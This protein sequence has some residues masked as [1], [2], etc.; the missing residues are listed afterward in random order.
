M[1]ESSQEQHR[2]GPI[3]Q[4]LLFHSKEL[5]GRQREQQLL[6]Q[7]FRRVGDKAT[8]TSE[9]VFVHGEAGAGKSALVQS[10][11]ALLLADAHHNDDL[12]GRTHLFA[13][14]KYEQQGT[15]DP[16]SAIS[17]V[18]SDLI[19]SVTNDNVHRLASI[20]TAILEAV[21]AEDL[22]MLPSLIPNLNRIVC[23]AQRRSRFTGRSNQEYAFSKLV[24]A[25]C[26]FVRSLIAATKPTVIVLDDMQFAPVL[27]I[28]LIRALASDKTIS[29]MLL[30]LTYRAGEGDTKR[31]S[32]LTQFLDTMLH[33]SPSEDHRFRHPVTEIKVGNLMLNDI[34]QIVR[35]ITKIQDDEITLPLGLVIVQK[36]QGHAFHVVQFLEMLRSR[37]LMWYENGRYIFDIARIRQET[38]VSENVASLVTARV[39]MLPLTTQKILTIAACF[40][41]SFAV[42]QFL[43]L[44]VRAL[45]F[46]PPV[47]MEAIDQQ[48]TNAVKMKVKEALM[49]GVAEGLLEVVD[50]THVKFSHDG[51]QQ[52]LLDTNS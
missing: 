32:S 23:C 43:G 33:Q 25:V 30:V 24:A 15:A 48:P 5:Y 35:G 20:R 11:D 1:K 50:E 7:A 19:K 6:L 34:D 13:I 37:R 36:T 26:S 27:S 52:A 40:K 10:I 12:L 22:P 21:D 51:V 14:G 45:S 47:K 9:I 42:E 41:F 8:P 4:P 44:A 3:P 31:H 2:T 39:Q 46:Y 29:G 18:L 28:D 16:Y 49:T 38:N 17:S